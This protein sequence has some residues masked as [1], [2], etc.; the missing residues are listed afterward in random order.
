MSAASGVGVDTA[1]LI[2]THLITIIYECIL[3]KF[4]GKKNVLVVRQG[5]R[6]SANPDSRELEPGRITPGKPSPA[7]EGIV[8]SPRVISPIDHAHN[9]DTM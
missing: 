3:V 5:E 4:F 7:R 9:P 1:A 6:E 8:R 2:P